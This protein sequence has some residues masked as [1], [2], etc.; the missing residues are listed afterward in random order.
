MFEIID[1][2]PNTTIIKV[3]GVGGAG[4]NAV[5]HMIKE[6]VGG[7]EFICCNTD[8]QALK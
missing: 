3:I 7:V 5:E 1:R 4:G 8:A 2:D 6:G